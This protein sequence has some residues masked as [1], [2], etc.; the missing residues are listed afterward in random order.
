[1]FDRITIRE[2][3]KYDPLNP[4]DIGLLLETMIFY[5]KTTIVCDGPGIL[6]Q[7]LKVFGEKHLLELVDREIL[8]LVYSESFT[9]IKT[10]TRP[11]GSQ[12]H[13]PV[14]FSS[15]Q[16]TFPI[17]LQRT[18]VELSGKE[19]K[20]RRMAARL[21]K[22]VTVS[23]YQETL[24][25]GVRSQIL[26]RGYLSHLYPVLLRSW[27]PELS[28][29]DI[30]S[31][32]FHAEE[33]KLGLVVVTNLNFDALNKLYHTRVSPSH[34]TLNEAFILSH[35]FDLETDLYHASR[36]LSE[37]SS[38]EQKSQLID[39]RL[40]Y[41]AERC[42]K[43]SGEKT[44]FQRTVIPLMRTVRE[45]FNAGRIPIE[46][47]VRVIL[48]AERF[49]S[50]LEGKSIDANLVQEYI[51]AI[52]QKTLLDRLPTKVVRWTSFTGAG[53][54]A[55]LLLTSGVGTAVG[56][57][58]SALDAFLLEK[59]IGGWKPDQFVEQYLLGLFKE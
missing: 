15:P 3:N 6:K 21:S 57:G 14:V 42:R 35:L 26:D 50:W 5:R 37:I 43:S 7:V 30:E 16:H 27:M 17:E 51:A 10:D 54:F 29:Q 18:C 2:H 24:S 23:N 4:I 34:S 59:V 53:I 31:F 44:T 20:G 40:R 48:E 19:G 56:V 52:S 49:K 9:G 36:N 47:I 1:M 11:D 28:Q 55:D 22:R 38:T 13:E 32:V 33:T 8:E 41:L 58:L 46:E 39:L 45:E 25:L 12:F